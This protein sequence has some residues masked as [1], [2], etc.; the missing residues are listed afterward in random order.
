MFPRLAERR[1]LPRVAA[2]F[3]GAPLRQY[4]DDQRTVGHELKARDIPGFD[5]GV[6]WDVWVLFD[7]KAT[8]DTA[9]DHVVG[10]GYTVVATREDLYDRLE[11]VA[12]R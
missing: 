4:W 5:G 8:W 1:A 9:G 7:E 12:K 10:W 2:E 3:E 11:S 6:A